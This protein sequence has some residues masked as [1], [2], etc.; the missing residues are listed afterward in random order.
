MSLQDP[1]VPKVTV[2][3]LPRGPVIDP[4]TGQ[5]TP[6]GR[7]YFERRGGQIGEIL[8]GVDRNAFNI[9]Q[10]ETDY[11]AADGAISNAYISADA[12]VASDAAGARAA[13]Q[14]FLES[15]FQA[16]DAAIQADVDA[17]AA[18]ISTKASNTR[19]DS[20]ES[21]LT[22]SIASVS[23][24]VTAETQAR[25]TA[26]NGLQADIN[27]R[28][29]NTRVDQVESGAASSLASSVAAL[30]A[31]YQSGDSGLQSQI[32]TE[33]L[34]RASGDA[35]EASARETLEARFDKTIAPSMFL[36]PDD[37]TG[38]AAGTPENVASWG[39]TS[40][41]ITNSYGGYG[42]AWRRA[43]VATIYQ[44]AVFSLAQ[45]D[46]FTIR[47][48]GAATTIP[49]DGSTR[50]QIIIIAL[51]ENF[52][53]VGGR[54]FQTSSDRTSPGSFELN[55]EI[56]SAQ[57]LAIRAGAVYARFG[58]MVCW[59][60]STDAVMDSRLFE[61]SRGPTAA[62][63]SV[64]KQAFI[65][66]NGDALAQFRVT[67]AAGGNPARLSL[68]DGAGGSN[69]ALDAD[70]I[71]FGSDTVF[72]D[73]H[74]TFYTTGG[75]YRYRDRGPFGSSGDL[76]QWYGPTSVSLNSETK[77]NG[78]W[79]LATDGKAYIGSNPVN[80]LQSASVAPAFDST[81]SGASIGTLGPFTITTNGGDGTYT[82][83]TVKIYDPSSVFTVVDGNT[84]TPEVDWSV[85]PDGQYYEAGFITTVT[86]TSTGKKAQVA[87]SVALVTIEPP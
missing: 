69:I 78:I 50:A 38:V 45:T 9:V 59:N 83:A 18:L 17:N 71:F 87:Y 48:V 35:A 31:A 20:V 30:T 26:D 33:S 47:Y 73:T 19:V 22:G 65:D 51:D 49:A 64:L 76:L 70:E 24:S 36:S 27:T 16:G 28:A 14:T 46:T 10:L 55:L 82:Y 52:A 6:A 5:F 53:Q 77:T 25:Q 81:V 7:A 74:D 43:G 11:T 84:S 34:A 63:V 54:I 3:P 42:K 37:W 75:S 39:V 2:E 21:T 80:S 66:S 57:I 56:T 32:T 29:T 62:S 15:S 67:A 1:I 23:A 4:R 86:E 13:L 40:E 68:L 58:V 8:S 60:D 79:A 12:V 61:V 85:T 44:K 72:E 41:F